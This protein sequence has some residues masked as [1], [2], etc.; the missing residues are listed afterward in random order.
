MSLNSICSAWFPDSRFQL[1]SRCQYWW[2]DQTISGWQEKHCA[3]HLSLCP[4][5][6]HLKYSRFHLASSFQIP[7]DTTKPSM[8]K[9]CTDYQSLCCPYTVSAQF[10]D[11]SWSRNGGWWVNLCN[12]STSSFI[13]FESHIFTLQAY[14]ANHFIWLSWPGQLNASSVNCC[15]QSP[16]FH[17]WKTW[18]HSMTVATMDLWRWLLSGALRNWDHRFLVEVQKYQIHHPKYQ[19]IHPKKQLYGVTY[20]QLN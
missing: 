10:R 4:H 11:F 7:G 9:R 15:K 8:E 13:V 18:K 3:D 20:T 5:T 19:N 16:T 12:S 1:T 17:L 14:S 6:A 2:H